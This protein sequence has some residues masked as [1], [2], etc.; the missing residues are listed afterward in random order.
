M[1]FQVRQKPSSLRV[2]MDD[3]QKLIQGRFQG[4]SGTVVCKAFLA[5]A[6]QMMPKCLCSLTDQLCKGA[7]GH[8]LQ[9]PLL[10]CTR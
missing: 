6:W 3:V 4:Q 7:M 5:C 9:R 10:G 2:S 8:D 1:A